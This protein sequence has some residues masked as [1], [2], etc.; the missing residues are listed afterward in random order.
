MVMI[1]NLFD[2]CSIYVTLSKS[3]IFTNLIAF[4]A[5]KT[6]LNTVIKFILILRGDIE[7]TNCNIEK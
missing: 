1:V 5:D 7:V 6:A 3:L 4:Y 2:P